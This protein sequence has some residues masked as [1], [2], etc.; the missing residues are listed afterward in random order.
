MAVYVDTYRGKLG[1]MTM[2]HMIADTLEELHAMAAQIGMKREWFQD[3][4]KASFPH[5][6]LSLTRR[7]MAVEAGAIE[8]D[9]HKLVEIITRLR[10][11]LKS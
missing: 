5:Y 6:D 3:R 9:K 4:P 2:C 1:R 7:K 8:V 10:Q 11:K